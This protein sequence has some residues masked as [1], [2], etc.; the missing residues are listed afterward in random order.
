M[1][2]DEPKVF[3]QEVVDT[4]HDAIG[5]GIHKIIALYLEEVPKDLSKIQQMLD[6]G[7]L[8]TLHRLAHSLKA[9]SAN[10][11]AMQTSALAAELEHSIAGGEKDPAKLSMMLQQIKTS[12]DQ[13]RTIFENLQFKE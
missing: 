10:L 12:F 5:D 4:L 6:T 8:E 11:G 7:E 2:G 9:S 3:D 1:S 13:T